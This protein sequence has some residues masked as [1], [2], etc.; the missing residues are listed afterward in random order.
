MFKC[1]AELGEELPLER[2]RVQVGLSESHA[3]S[4][5]EPSQA[6]FSGLWGPPPGV[7]W[8]LKGPYPVS[9]RGPGALSSAT[10]V[11]QISHRDIFSSM[12]WKFEQN[13]AFSLPEGFPAHLF[14]QYHVNQHRTESLNLRYVFGFKVQPGY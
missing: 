8:F 10:K 4:G 3:L 7:L 6:Q 5:K 13:S 12:L 14:F 1:R 9:Q 2:P 11:R